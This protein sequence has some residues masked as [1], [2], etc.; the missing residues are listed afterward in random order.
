MKKLLLLVSVLLSIFIRNNTYAQIDDSNNGCLFQ[1]ECVFDYTDSLFRNMIYDSR[2][3]YSLSPHGSIRLLLIFV[4]LEYDNPDNDPYLTGS[5]YWDIDT[6]PK[7]ANQLYDTNIPVGISE[8]SVTK[9]FQYASSNDHIVLGDYLLAPDN[10]GVF[11]IRT[12]DGNM[13]PKVNDIIDSI[14]LKL[15]NN[16]ITAANKT[17][18]DFD[19]WTPSNPGCIKT[20]SGNNKW[21]FVAIVMRNSNNPNNPNGGGVNITHQL[22]GHYIDKGCIVC[23]GDIALPDKILRHEYAHKLMG[24][25]NTHTCGGGWSHTFNYWIPQTGGWALMGLYSSSLMCWSAWDR[26][27]LGWKTADYDI[28][29][30]SEDG[31]TEINGDLNCSNGNEIYILRDFVTTGDAIRIKL[32]FIKKGLE[33]QEW[34]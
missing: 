1:E 34:L 12:S 32:P 21:D 3:G 11:K 27:R 2:N 26:Y 15:G 8:K 14:N 19:M 17:F 5:D 28:S 13:R 20:P 6:L 31:L 18:A 30:R 23:A 25:N 10:Y 16:I 7:W 29:A 22:L 9:Y 24:N 4:E 33:Y